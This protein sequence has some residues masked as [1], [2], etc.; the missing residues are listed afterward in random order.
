MGQLQE[1]AKEFCEKSPLS[2]RNELH[3]QELEE[4]ADEISALVHEA[5]R[6]YSLTQVSTPK[7]LFVDC[8]FRACYCVP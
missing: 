3:G 4:L 2:T 7:L 1:D 8:M 5:E 6:L